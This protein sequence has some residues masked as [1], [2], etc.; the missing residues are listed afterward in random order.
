MDW[1]EKLHMC[2]SSLHFMT[3][4]LTNLSE[5]FYMTGNSTVGKKLYKMAEQAT[6]IKADI[7]TCTTEI[8][9]NHVTE[10]NQRAATMME[11]A[12]AIK[13]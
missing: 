13:E 2:E 6:N 12:M 10:A 4:R 7:E 8:L 5:S 9:N 1:L 11:L 3:Q